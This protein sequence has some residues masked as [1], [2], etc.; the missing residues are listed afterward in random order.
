MDTPIAIKSNYLPSPYGWKLKDNYYIEINDTRLYG[1]WYPTHHLKYMQE[2]PI[3][4]SLEKQLD[5][6]D[7]YL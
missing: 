7:K 6:L 3:K 5:F 1:F 4:I 2:K